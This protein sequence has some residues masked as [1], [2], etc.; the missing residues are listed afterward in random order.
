M[1][2]AAKI[3][4]SET[5]DLLSPNY[6]DRVFL[7]AEN[8]LKVQSLSRSQY[9]LFKCAL[10]GLREDFQEEEIPPFIYLPRL[11]CAGLTGDAEIALPLSVATTLLF[12]GVDILDDLAD[13]DLP[14]YWKGYQTSQIQLVSATLLSSLPQIAISE[15]EVSETCRDALQRTLAQGLLRMSAGQYQ[16]LSMNGKDNVSSQEVEASVAAKSGE[17]LALF[18]ALAAQFSGAPPDLVKVYTDMGRAIGTAGQLASDCYDIFQAE[19]S[20]DLANGTRTFPIALYLEKKTLEERKLFLDLLERAKESEGVVDMIRATL[21]SSGILRLSAFVVEVY[22]QRAR[23][24]L[25]A[26]AP[27][28]IAVSGLEKFIQKNSFF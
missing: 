19:K 5:D 9:Q 15:L 26:A 27:R 14:S 1:A 18:T 6:K 21:H 17:E 10:D 12:L 25:T 24:L 16:D 23:T 28:D 13:G 4:F 22:C 11:V 20:K 7:Q 3:I 8:F 2:L